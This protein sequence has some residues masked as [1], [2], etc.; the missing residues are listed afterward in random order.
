MFT[1]TESV[2]SRFCLTLTDHCFSLDADLRMI[3]G[4]ELIFEH[5]GV[6][7]AQ[8]SLPTSDAEG[9]GEAGPLSIIIYYYCGFN[10]I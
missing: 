9:G 6:R 7:C 5:F 3:E 4:A 10:F 8:N 1:N 2:F